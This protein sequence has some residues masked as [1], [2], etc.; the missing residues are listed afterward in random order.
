MQEQ[1]LWFLFGAYLVV[2]FWSL[3]RLASKRRNITPPVSISMVTKGGCT[4]V[5]RKRDT[6]S[7]HSPRN[8][9]V[10]FIIYKDG[11]RIGYLENETGKGGH[12]V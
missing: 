12:H 4:P 1:I 7:R 3:E 9:V 10:G 5:V 2:F 11:V 6:R 8:T